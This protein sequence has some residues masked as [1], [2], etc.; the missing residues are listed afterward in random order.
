MRTSSLGTMEAR[1]GAKA[2][3]VT[4]SEFTVAFIPFGLLL[5]AALLA[6]EETL[7]FGLSRAIYTI[8]AATVL[9]TP[10]LCAFALPGTS[11]RKQNIWLLFWT[12]SL[13]VFLVHVGYAYFSVYHGSPREFVVGQ[14][15][16]IG[17]NNLIFML[18]WIFDVTLAWL[19]RSPRPWVN[20]QRLWAHIYIGG[21][22]FVATIILK[23]G[24]IT[25]IGAAMTLAVVVSLAI[26]FDR[27]RG[28][29]DDF[30]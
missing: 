9:V 3:R 19:L 2:Y 1:S 18:W 16:F 14:G 6:A 15:V 22:F 12:F 4:L 29:R 25:A 24:V 28:V 11:A 8:W 27:L 17:T 23:H 13:I 30:G 5:G 21:T 10:A 20:T 26:R 7:D